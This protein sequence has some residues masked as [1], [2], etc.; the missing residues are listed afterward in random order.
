MFGK[1]ENRYASTRQKYGSVLIQ[2][3]EEEEDTKWIQRAEY[4]AFESQIFMQ[5]I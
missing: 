5:G 4:E 3:R 2:D 1:E